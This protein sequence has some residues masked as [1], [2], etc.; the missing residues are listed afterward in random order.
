MP[1]S[2]RGR[3][4]SGFR[5]APLGRGRSAA[6]TR[7]PTVSLAALPQRLAR[8]PVGPV[9]RLGTMRVLE[10]LPEL[11]SPAPGA[12]ETPLEVDPDC[13]KP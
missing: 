6:S 12:V 7:A 5:G 2:A 8:Q 13:W 3:A 1:R 10:A 11:L 4:D 9:R